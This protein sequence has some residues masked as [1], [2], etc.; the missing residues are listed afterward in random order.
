MGEEDKRYLTI[1]EVKELITTEAEERELTY[2]QTLALGH[3]E[4]FAVLTVEDAKKLVEELDDTFEFMNLK[5]AYKTA[6]I[7][8]REISGVRAI[9]ARDRYTPSEEDCDKIIKVIKKHM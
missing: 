5:L 4:K 9:F 3:S 2:E 6:D 1:P 8:P 7:L